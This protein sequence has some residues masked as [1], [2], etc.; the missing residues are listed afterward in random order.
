ML[1]TTEK[2]KGTR[3]GGNIV[4]PPDDTPTLSDIGI[5]KIQSHRWQTIATLPAEELKLRAERKLG[6]LLQETTVKGGERHKFHDE[7]YERV[8]T[9]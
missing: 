6:E 2:N 1:A 9:L 8:P 3:L 5:D 4:K 7:T